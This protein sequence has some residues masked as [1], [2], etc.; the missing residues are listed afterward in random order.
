[1]ESFSNHT[2]IIK[3]I[4]VFVKGGFKIKLHITLK[5]AYPTPNGEAGVTRKLVTIKLNDRQMN[6]IFVGAW[7]LYPLEEWEVTPEQIM[8][9][10]DEFKNTLKELRNL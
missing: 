8:F 6:E 3:K 10:S 7:K 2:D 9:D 4:R 5:H 1:M